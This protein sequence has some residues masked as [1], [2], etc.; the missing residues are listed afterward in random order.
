MYIIAYGRDTLGHSLRIFSKYYYFYS[1]NPADWG[2]L[3]SPLDPAIMAAL[4]DCMG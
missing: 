3:A 2:V 4:A 1:E